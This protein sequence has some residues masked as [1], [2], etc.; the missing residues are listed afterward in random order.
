[1]FIGK[2]L[3]TVF[4]SIRHQALEQYFRPYS[5]VDLVRMAAAFNAPSVLPSPLPVVP[6]LVCAYV[7]SRARRV[8]A[9]ISDLSDLI[10]AGKIQG[11]IDCRKKV[12][13]PVCFAHAGLLGRVMSVRCL[14]R[15]GVGGC[16]CE[17]ARCGISK[18]PGG[19]SSLRQRGKGAS[20]SASFVSLGFGFVCV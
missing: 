6:V 10:M 17:S 8:E 15:A 9:I 14:W 7:L 18:G 16:G 20:P 4:R 13:V 5:S 11:R 19:G 12:R 3:E 2:C 1:M